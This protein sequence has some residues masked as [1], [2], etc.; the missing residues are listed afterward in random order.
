[1]S[2]SQ[3]LTWNEVQRHSVFKTSFVEVEER[4]YQLPDGSVLEK[5]AMFIEADGVA[6]VALTPGNKFI[7][8]RQFRTVPAEVTIDFAGGAVEKGEDPLGS[9]QRELLEETGYQSTE[10]QPLG[11]VLP[12][13]HRLVSTIFVFL[14]KNCQKVSETN[15]DDNEFLETVLLSRSELDQMIQNDTMNC[16]ICLSSYLKALPHL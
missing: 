8:V 9:A 12:A 16:G 15:E 13:Q 4:D 14:A 11:S 7:F 2:T 6:V 3:Q 1:M 5:Y 10:W